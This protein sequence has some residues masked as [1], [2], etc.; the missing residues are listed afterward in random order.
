MK[1]RIFISL[2]TIFLAG[3][4]LIIWGII[5]ASFLSLSSF[6]VSLNKGDGNAIIIGLGIVLV[7]IVFFKVLD[8]I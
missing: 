3:L 8:S 7:L 5:D 6:F 4:A 1:Y 2:T